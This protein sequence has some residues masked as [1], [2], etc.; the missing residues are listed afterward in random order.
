MAFF[1][2]ISIRLQYENKIVLVFNDQFSWMIVF[3]YLGEAMVPGTVAKLMPLLAPDVKI[4]NVY[5]PAECSM[6]STTHLVTKEDLMTTSVPIGRPL[7]NYT[8]HI[9]DEHLT[10]VPLNSVGELFIG[11][12]GVFSGYLTNDPSLNSKALVSLPNHDEANKFYRTGDLCCLNADGEIVYVGRADFQVK[13]RGQRLELGEIEACI[14]RATPIHATN[15]AVIKCKD[16]QSHDEFLGAYIQAAQ[17]ISPQ[18]YNSIRATVMKYCTEHLPPF[19]VPSAWLVLEALPLSSNDKIDRKRLPPISR[20]PQ[21]PQVHIEPPTPQPVLSSNP[22]MVSSS[23]YGSIKDKVSEIFSCALNM[24]ISEVQWNTSFGELGG[25]SLSAMTVVTLVRERLYPAME[26]GLLFQHPSVH[27]L[28]SV[29]IQSENPPSN[30]ST[31]APV[32]SIRSRSSTLNST[33]TTA[34]QIEPELPKD[35][36]IIDWNENHARPSVIIELIGILLLVYHYLYPAWVSI[37]IIGKI[38]LYREFDVTRSYGLTVLA[39]LVEVALLLLLMS[40]IQLVTYIVCK[41]LLVGRAEPGKYRLFTFRYY[42]YWF[43]HRIWC[44]NSASLN[45]ILG[46]PIYNLYLRL[47]GAQIGHNVHINTTLIDS[48][49]LLRIGDHTYI[50]ASVTL[51]AMSYTQHTYCLD[52]II[53]GS[54]CS[55]QTRV[56][57]Q[58]GV[59]IKTNV[60][61]KS[62]SFVSGNIAANSI[63]DGV[64]VTPDAR[65]PVDYLFGTLVL[66]WMQMLYQLICM[67]FVFLLQIIILIIIYATY[68]YLFPTALAY[69]VFVGFP[70]F[71]LMLTFSNVLIAIFA[72]LCLVGRVSPGNHPVNSWSF[73]HKIWFRQLI[74]N[75]FGGSFFIFGGY[76]ALYPTFLRW[77][78]AKIGDDVKIGDIVTLLTGPSNL[79]RTGDGVTTNGKCLIAPIDVIDGRCLMAK[80]HIGDHSTLGNAITIH[81]GARIPDKCMIGTATRIEPDV[82]YNENKIIIGVPARELPFGLPTLL[83]SV[84][85][86][87]TEISCCSRFWSSVFENFLGIALATVL[88]KLIMAICGL[89]LIFF[90]FIDRQSTFLTLTNIF[91]LLPPLYFCF[92]VL[93]S[94]ALSVCY[95]LCNRDVWNVG[96][97]RYKTV[98]SWRRHLSWCLLVD[99]YSC[100]GNFIAGSQWLVYLMRGM[101]ARIGRSVVLSDLFNLIDPQQLIIQDNVRIS[102]T[103]SVQVRIITRLF[104]SL[105]KAR[106]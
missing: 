20:T 4:Y 31:P 34:I 15:C 67:I 105:Q 17:N 2:D 27:A 50:G 80:V 86:E 40:I 9:L 81:S 102:G 54:N 60:L 65:Q 63:I 16:E 70:L 99:F 13:L 55:I 26:I 66:S 57:L 23:P 76:H 95:R 68:R 6:A 94:C 56:T 77:F 52:P 1:K 104:F 24:P 103:A 69:F 3:L 62:M 46:T 82:V 51:A 83:N 37:I 22:L 74:V 8:C 84:S 29:L 61:V 48:P 98:I 43:V 41:W 39:A 78:G 64:N 79:I 42:R 89:C 18:E 5:G 38:P 73:L 87:D 53:I 100:V 44:L 49:D 97:Y 75:T 12:P 96:T 101:G 14:L 91:L 58:H 36:S 11:G 30:L 88:A 59:Y 106:Q 90:V 93:M 25:N 45:V 7:P 32:R 85:V 33:V 92:M 72:L 47:C 21:P 28:S 35:E 71:W 10:L 19:M